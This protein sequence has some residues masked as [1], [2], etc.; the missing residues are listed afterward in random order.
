MQIAVVADIHGNALALDAVAADIARRRPD[1]V[2]NLGD[3]VSGPL[4]PAETAARLRDLGWPSVRGNH[5]RQI[6]TTPRALMGASDAF[7]FDRLMPPEREHLGALP[8]TLTLQSGILAF[9]GT[10]ADDTLYLLEDVAGERLVLSDEAA[11]R[12]RLGGARAPVLLCGH[13]HQPRIVMGDRGMLIVNPGSVGCP[14][15]LDPEPRHVS[16]TGSPHARCALLTQR[17]GVWTVELIALDYDWHA[18]ARQACKEGRAE[19]ARALGTGF[20]RGT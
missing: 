10:P 14:A 18:A 8:E 15:Y 13:S 20:V 1:L 16:E 17:G 4:W 6:A 9:H 19:W 11:I 5:D 12:T 7:A 2:I 3:C